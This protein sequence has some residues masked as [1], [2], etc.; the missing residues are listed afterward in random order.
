VA[1]D[2][3]C[4]GKAL[5]GGYMT[6]AATLCTPALAAAVSGGEAHGLMHGPTFMA[7]PLACSV[8]LASL[9]LLA[10]GGWRERVAAIEDGLR[11]GLAP[12]RE[13]PGVVDVR[14]LG[15]IGVI[16][17]ERDV[18]V[19]AATNAAVERGVWLRPFR[20]LIYTMPPYV[21]EPRE[22]AEVTGAMVAAAGAS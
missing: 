1:P 13:L 18:D 19:A 20:D 14:V 2:V 10:D 17:F 6:L 12:A 21:I 5:T 15:A 3:M 8:A 11:A 9:D 22:L 7:N 4:V 16:Q